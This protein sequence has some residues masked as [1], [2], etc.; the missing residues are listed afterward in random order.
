M[1]TLTLASD[2]PVHGSYQIALLGSGVAQTDPTNEVT[3]AAGSIAPGA[4]GPSGLP[5]QSKLTTFGVPATDDAGDLAYTA[6][7]TAST[8]KGT[9]LFL[10]DQCLAILGSAFAPIDRA[11][12]K[13]FGVPVVDAG[14]VVL[15]ASLSG[16][17]VAQAS[18]ILAGGSNLD[19]IAQ[20][21]TF[22]PDA[23]GLTSASS[24]KFKTFRGVA[25]RGGTIAIFAQVVGGVGAA[26]ATALNDVGI[27][28]KMPGGALFR[29]FAE[30]DEPIDG[31]FARVLTS[32]AVGNGSPGQGRGWLTT[33]GTA[34]APPHVLIYCTLSGGLQGVFDQSAVHTASVIALTKQVS[35]GGPDIGGASF[36]SIGVPA[37]NDAGNIVFRAS[38]TLTKNIASAATAQGIFMSEG[39][40][41]S[42]PLAR[43]GDP[44]GS[45]GAT[46]SVLKDP[47]LGE[48][49]G[50][51]FPATIKGSTAKGL[52]A[53]TLWWQPPAGHLELLAQAGPNNQGIPTDLPTGAQWS[54]FTSLAIAENRGPLFTG[55]LTPG[56]GGA[57]AATASGLWA[58]DANGKIRTLFRTGDTTLISGKVLTGINVLKASVGSMGVSRNFSGQGEIV[59]LAT[60]K[61]KSQAVITTE[62][63]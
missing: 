60:F 37:A 56:K 3:L 46:F 28:L 5:A 34:G 24:P 22:A 54:T 26:K 8:G 41:L 7:W 55:T 52:N 39:A 61:D 45:T 38:L 36:A 31:N 13:T 48:D 44:A 19:L 30:N 21:G 62:V 27:W 20:A 18:V 53:T 14:L 58:V 35:F 15:P 33:P 6:Q 59:W 50:I 51:A 40:T 23:A 2:D 57:T 16:V 43:M 49:G 11:K 47:V 32:F 9:G 29:V 4:D 12:Y 17:P 1:A 25:T 10:N 42:H 63:P